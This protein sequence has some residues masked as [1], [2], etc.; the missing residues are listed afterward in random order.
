[1]AKG[2]KITQKT[3]LEEPRLEKKGKSI[4]AQSMVKRLTPIVADVTIYV[5]VILLLSAGTNWR[6]II[7]NSD[8]EL[9]ADCVKKSPDKDRP[10]NNLGNA[11][12]RQGRYQ[13]AIPQYTEALRINPNDITAHNNLGNAFG[14]Q[15]RYQEAI[16][17]F[18]EALRINPNLAEAHYNLGIACFMIGNRNLALKEY[19]ILKTMNPGLANALYQMIK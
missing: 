5:F 11:F 7:W 12:G 9:W 13:E 18:T 17:Q 19:E 4:T 3:Y 16:A 8:M 10:H 6:N 1:M 14:R 2:I 15:G